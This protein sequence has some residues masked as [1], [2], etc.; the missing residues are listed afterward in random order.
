MNLQPPR[1]DAGE[2]G[3]GVGRLHRGTGLGEIPRGH[4]P[5]QINH[6]E[7][8]MGLVQI[9][10]GGKAVAAVVNMAGRAEVAQP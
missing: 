7:T 10:D 5:R 2:L 6:P 3:G 9:K 8:G 1:C 4:R